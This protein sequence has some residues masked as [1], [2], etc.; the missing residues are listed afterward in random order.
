MWISSHKAFRSAA[1]LAVI[2]PLVFAAPY[3]HHEHEAAETDNCDACLHHR[4][5]AAHLSSDT[6]LQDC[7]ICQILSVQF[8]PG[9]Q[10][11]VHLF[12]AVV[13]KVFTAPASASAYVF[14]PSSPGRAPPVSFCFQTICLSAF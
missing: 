6:S 1:L 2:L 10:G 9:K 7:L 3:H 8:T 5:H 11:I 14:I 13:G 12:R 4:P